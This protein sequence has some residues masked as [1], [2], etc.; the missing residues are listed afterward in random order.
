MNE[1][2]LKEA[3]LT[4]GEIKVY[5]SM[6]KIGPS[7][8]GPIVESS[9][10][11]KSIV[12]QILDKLIDKGLV[13]YIT[14]DKTKYFQASNPSQIINYLDKKEIDFARTRKDVEELIVE[15][16]Q[17]KKANKGLTAQIYTGFRGVQTAHENSYEK[18]NAGDEYFYI[19]IFPE[20]EE[21][22][23][24]Y[25]ERDHKRRIK[26][27]IK[28]RL[29]F[30]QGTETKIVKNRNNYKG[31]EA[32]YMPMNIKTPAWFMGY[33]NTIV[34]GLQEAEIA[35]EIVNQKIADSFKSYFE[36]FWNKSKP[37]Y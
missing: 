33:K 30:N 6:L 32:R 17:I 10:I 22:F 9:K 19:G 27:G 21:K 4:E 8:T 3:G 24:L 35:I 13:S 14:K 23:H 26:A 29:M 36:E 15:L 11:S 34:I 20:Q 16:A 28:C 2:I 7:T 1:K 18:L 31:C 25:W 37:F 12:Y 5:L